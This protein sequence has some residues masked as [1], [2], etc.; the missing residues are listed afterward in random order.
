MIVDSVGGDLID[1]RAAPSSSG[2]WDE[3]PSSP[4]SEVEI[5]VGGWG[6]AGEIG[7]AAGADASGVVFAGLVGAANGLEIGAEFGFLGLDSG[8]VEGR[9]NDGHEHADDAHGDEGFDEGEAAFCPHGYGGCSGF[10]SLRVRW[11]CGGFGR[12]LRSTGN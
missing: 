12:R 2:N 4:S 6:C 3:G 10:L 9:P 5:A 1:V 8:F 7:E 11:F